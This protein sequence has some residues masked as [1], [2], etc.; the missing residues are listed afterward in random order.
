MT[1]R[2]IDALTLRLH[3]TIAEMYEEWTRK[4]HGDAA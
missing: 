4:A 3:D 2:D 1:M